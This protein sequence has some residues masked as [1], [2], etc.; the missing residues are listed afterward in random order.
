MCFL[1]ASSYLYIQKRA[2]VHVLPLLASYG[3]W[4]LVWRCERVCNC[5]KVWAAAR[6]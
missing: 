4:K 1:Q 5:E 3:P 2:A 6:A